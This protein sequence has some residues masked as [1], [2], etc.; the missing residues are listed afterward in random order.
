MMESGVKYRGQK[1]KEP[2]SRRMEEGERM[3]PSSDLI[4]SPLAFPLAYFFCAVSFI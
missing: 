2:K 4:F 1:K 3:V